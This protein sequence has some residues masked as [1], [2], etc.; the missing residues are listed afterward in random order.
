[1]LDFRDINPPDTIGH[2]YA[3]GCQHPHFKWYCL[4]SYGL[5]FV[6]TLATL[7]LQYSNDL[8]GEDLKPGI[9]DGTCFFGS[10]FP[11]FLYF[12]VINGLALVISFIKLFKIYLIQASLWGNPSTC[13]S[14]NFHMF[15]YKPSIEK[16]CN[17]IL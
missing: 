16:Y 1:M 7:F 14:L 13:D 10:S 6:I 15:S 2:E 4:F 17:H 5:P 12:K 3:W 8:L 11:E 9:G